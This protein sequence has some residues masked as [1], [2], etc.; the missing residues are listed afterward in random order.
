M[1]MGFIDLVFERGGRYWVLDFKTNYLGADGSAYD[2]AS[3]ASAMLENRYDVQSAIYLFALHRL[4]QRRLGD[5]YDP[6][7]HL[8]GAI[9]FFLRGIDGPEGGIH[10]QPASPAMLQELD[11]LFNASAVTAVSA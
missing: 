3:M 7:A 8:G 10:V 9:Y 4:L 1:L 11:G 5:S 2:E 6:E